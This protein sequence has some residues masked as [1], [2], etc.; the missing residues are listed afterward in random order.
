[1][2]N[3]GYTQVIDSLQQMI[4]PKDKFMYLFNYLFLY[5]HTLNGILGDHLFLFDTYVYLSISVVDCGQICASGVA[6]TK[7][8]V[9]KDSGLKT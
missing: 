3:V 1:M 8:K 4:K 9:P 2:P 6:D 5:V 7:W